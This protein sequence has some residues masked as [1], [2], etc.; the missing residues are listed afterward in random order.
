MS[1]EEWINEMEGEVEEEV[2][3]N[4]TCDTIEVTNDF[5][6]LT[7]ELHQGYLAIK[8]RCKQRILEHLRDGKDT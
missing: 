2:I 1:E 8:E 6:K 5:V 3:E 7:E 4:N